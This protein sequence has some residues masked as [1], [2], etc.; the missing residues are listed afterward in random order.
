MIEE[1]LTLWS[2]GGS[3]FGLDD[4]VAGRLD[5]GF[6]L[7]LIGLLGIEGDGGLAGEVAD[8]VDA[9]DA[10]SF[11]EKGC[12]VIGAALAHHALD[13]EAGFMSGDG[14]AGVGN[15]LLNSGHLDLGRVIVDGEGAGFRAVLA[16][17]DAIHGGEGGF[18][19]GGP[20]FVFESCDGDL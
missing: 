17:C 8:F 5:D 15:C 1:K 16:G 20:G 19:F 4:L 10:G 18:G 3:W 7:S 2:S 9:E 14:E 13:F 6:D 12:N 11:A